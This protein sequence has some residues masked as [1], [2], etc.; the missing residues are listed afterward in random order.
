MP[1]KRKMRGTARAAQERDPPVFSCNFSGAGTG[2]AR[3][4]GKRSFNPEEQGK[5]EGE[6]INSLPPVKRSRNKH[7]R[8]Q[9][10]IAP[11][12]GVQWF[13][14]RKKMKMSKQEVK[15]EYKQQEGDQ[16][17]KSQR[18][19]K[20]MQLIN[21]MMSQ[22]KDSTV[23]V[24]NPTHLAIAIKYDKENNGAPVVV[25]K[26]ADNIAQM[27]REE[28]KKNNVPILENKP[29]ARSLYK[30]T[31]VGQAIPVDMYETV[32]EIL[33]FVYQANEQN[34]YKI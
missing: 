22:V 5:P 1:R 9:A 21:G 32:A 10:G 23:V 11:L 13:S 8:L 3:L 31:E 19:S 26:G 24:T 29:V 30:T 16:L 34:K 18:K 20:Y 6:R 12:N 28:A 7:A 33:A 4:D 27:I 15:D 25:A 14:F 2:K 17:V